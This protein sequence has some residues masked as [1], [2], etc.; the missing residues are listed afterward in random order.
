MTDIITLS[1]RHLFPLENGFDL[2]LG[3]SVRALRDDPEICLC[4]PVLNLDVYAVRCSD[5]PIEV[6][7]GQAALRFRP[8]DVGGRA[9]VVRC[10]DVGR[11]LAFGGT[12]PGISYFESPLPPVL[13]GHG[14]QVFTDKRQ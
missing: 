2:A 11:E 1:G 5:V 7:L 10:D 3:A 8:L 14:V 9:I 12:D 13:L 6:I 4:T